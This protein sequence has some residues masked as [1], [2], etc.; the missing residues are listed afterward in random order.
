MGPAVEHS[1][2]NDGFWG[3]LDAGVC[4]AVIGLALFW[5]AIGTVVWHLT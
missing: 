5:V 1:E 3:K 2:Q 4:A